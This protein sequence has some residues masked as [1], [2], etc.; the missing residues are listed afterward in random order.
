MGFDKPFVKR[1]V[2]EPGHVAHLLR[3]KGD[4]YTKIGDLDAEVIKSDEPIKFSELNKHAFKPIRKWSKW[5]EK[6]G[7]AWFRFTGKVPKKGKGKHVVLRIK[8]QGEGL[9]MNEDGIVLQGITQVLSKGDIFHSLIGK[10]VVD[11]ADKSTGDEE[12]KLYVDAGFNGKLRFENLVARLRRCDI[13]VCN[14]E[15]NGYYYDYIDLFFTMLKLPKDGARAKE[16]ES[17][18]NESFKAY[19]S[20][21]AAAAREILAPV[22]TK[23]IDYPCTEYYCIGHAH[24]DLAW[25]WPWRETRR[26]VA[27]TFANQLRN[28]DKYDGFLFAES[29]PQMWVWLEEDYP[30]LFERVCRAVRDGRI[31]TQGAM[32]VEGDC[33]LSSGESWIRQ[34]LYGKKYWKEKFG[35]DTELCWLPDVFGFP[36]T[37]P[38]VLRGCGMKYFM[39]IKILSNTVNQFPYK[40]F[41]WEGLDG[42]Q[43]LAHMEPLGDYNSGASPLAI[44]KSEAR[45]TEKGIIPKALL[46]YGDGDGGGGPGEGHIE[47]VKRHRNM[48]GLAPC[49]MK[50]SIDL[51]RDIEPYEDVMPHYKGELYYERHQGTYTSQANTKKNNRMMERKLHELEWIGSL[52]RLRGVPYDSKFAEKIWKETLLY[53][54]HDVLP[55][56][57]IKRVYDECAERY[58]VMA[59]ETD[60][61]IK[62]YLSEISSE[63]KKVFANETPFSRSEYVQ[64]DG[65]WL[66]AEVAPYS[67]T[68]DATEI[69]VDAVAAELAYDDATIENSAIV[70][71]FGENGEILSMYDKVNDKELVGEYFNRLVLYSDPFMYYNAWD[72]NMDYPNMRKET[73]RLLSTRTYV[74]GVKVVREQSFGHGKTALVQKI[75]L[76]AGDSAV[77]FDTTVEWDEEYKMLRADFSPAFFADEVACDIQFGTFRRSTLEDDSIRRAQFE[78]CAHKY[79]NI[80]SDDYGFALINNGKYGHRAKNG[81][82]SLCL[83]RS[84]KFP[85]PTCDIGT[86]TFSYAIYPHK[87][88]LED[89]DV[90]A[91]AYAFNYPLLETECDPFDFPVTVV[92]EGVVTETVKPSED[93][94]GIVLR[95][96]ESKGAETSADI[97][98]DFECRA[99]E[100]DMLENRSGEC[101]LTGLTF[102]PYEIKTILLEKI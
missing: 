52:C 88:K 33:N 91:R 34:S 1:A 22:L 2:A 41:I 54:F 80:D 90:L 78:I 24:I 25:L 11:V 50:R 84:P 81:F 35:T 85:D 97:R 96:F 12:I 7:C 39:T 21:G 28:I 82:L 66:K 13:A 76:T 59:E 47:Y 68:A 62:H 100:C 5:A 31:E 63:P 69:D 16:I 42:S 79:V 95:L 30:E 56:S 93:G 44:F 61:M 75:S 57:S 86:H 32:W 48:N 36:A 94:S 60:G 20:K 6:F 77:R 46:I 10:Q 29:Q 74:D 9:V 49:V 51:F 37:L 15:V 40:T 17:A 87:E 83:L 4:C 99:F 55:G 71:S 45:N 92:G 26:K 70:V 23:P 58:S 14:D 101:S 53:Q 18:L 89:S 65:K 98:S 72:I 38:Q 19:R 8:L 73:L 27:R 43:V 102:R 67:A 64:S 3:I